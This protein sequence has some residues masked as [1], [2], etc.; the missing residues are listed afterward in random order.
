MQE[1]ESASATAVMERPDAGDDARI[2]RG[3]VAHRRD[4]H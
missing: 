3:A 2:P 1:A 4:S